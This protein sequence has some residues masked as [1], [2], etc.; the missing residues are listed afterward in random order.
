MGIN[1]CGAHIRMPQQGLYRADIAASPQQLGSKSM[2]EGVTAGGLAQTAGVH[3]LFHCTL[4]GA[5]MH[6]MADRLPV[7]I[8][9]DARGGKQPLPLQGSG[10]SGVLTLERER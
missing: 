7:F 4:N 1:L 9:A 10:R 8:Q 5:D 2:S 6:V 3:R